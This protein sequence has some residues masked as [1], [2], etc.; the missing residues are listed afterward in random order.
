MTP[1]TF[2]IWRGDTSGGKYVDYETEAS[3]GMVVLDVV[4]KIQSTPGQ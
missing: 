4:H 3:E 1:V 2:K